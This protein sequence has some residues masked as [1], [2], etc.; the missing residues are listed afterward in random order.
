[1]R[2][3]GRWTEPG[4]V[5]VEP[6]ERRTARLLAS[7]LLMFILASVP[8]L[9]AE[10]LLIPGFLPILLTVTAALLVL[11]GAYVLSRGRWYR[12]AGA[13]AAIVL[14]AMCLASGLWAPKPEEAF[15]FA[16]LGVIFAGF[17][18]SSRAALAASALAISGSV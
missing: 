18:L 8:A 11:A 4:P 5:L 1:M 9:V 10:Q 17:V 14:V 12:A 15:P 2:W 3:W 6:E 7:L 16:L 13:I